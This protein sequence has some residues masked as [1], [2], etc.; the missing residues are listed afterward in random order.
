MES[1]LEFQ[2]NFRIVCQYQNIML[3]SE[4]KHQSRQRIFTSS[5]LSTLNQHQAGNLAPSSSHPISSEDVVLVVPASPSND[6]LPPAFSIISS[7]YPPD[8]S[9]GHGAKTL[10]SPSS[11][12]F[13]ELLKCHR[14]LGRP[15]IH[16]QA[17]VWLP[18]L[19]YP[20]LIFKK[21]SNYTSCIC[22]ISRQ[23]F[24]KLIILICLIANVLN[25]L[26]R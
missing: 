21:P 18:V 14:V 6:G 17:L 7:V 20:S 4:I 5:C 3:T 1:S 12:F 23:D 11:A 16:F 10:A 24:S 25:Y 13:Q 22:I 15:A 9:R 8:S 19:S 26:L 2:V